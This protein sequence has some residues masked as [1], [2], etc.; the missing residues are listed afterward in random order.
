MIEK[1]KKDTLEKEVTLTTAPVDVPKTDDDAATKSAA[2]TTIPVMSQGENL[3]NKVVYQCIN[4]WLN[5]GMSLVITDYFLHGK[6]K[7][8]HTNNLRKVTDF[9]KRT[10]IDQ[11]VG[12]AAT[13]RAVGVAAGF[14]TLLSGGNIL[15]IP[16]KI[17]EDNK[18]PIVHWLNKHVYHQQQL[19]PDGHEETSDEIYIEKEQPKQSW[20]NL[21]WRRLQAMAAGVA[22]GLALD[23]LGRKKLDI[24]QI[25][26]GKAI[27]KIDGQERYTDWVVTNINKALN[28]GV[29]PGGKSVA[30]N[31]T[32]HRYIGYAAL[33]TI[34]TL[35]TSMVMYMT[36][37][38]KKARM[39]HEIGD[40]VDPPGI[41]IK[42]GLGSDE[43]VILPKGEEIV[44]TPQAS[45]HANTKFNTKPPEPMQKHTDR[46]KRDIT[47][48]VAI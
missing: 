35:I 28:S 10:K 33:D 4:Y 24:P 8:V 40:D 30:E 3:Y 41:E 47:Y 31:P 46:A 34:Q 42:D 20:L 1:E 29:I 48:P 23:N 36:N 18:R 2:L 32:V 27:T 9:F 16:D 5:L 6:G 43:I 15:L 39:P 19:A 25:I 37:G 17:M 45:Q 21:G 44:D 38:A 13:K 14:I 12:E 26:N 7:G 11:V 22:F